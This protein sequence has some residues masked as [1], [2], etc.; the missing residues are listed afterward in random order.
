MSPGPEQS[1]APTG[2]SFPGLL[3]PRASSWA[4]LSPAGIS[5]PPLTAALICF[6]FQEL[7]S[8]VSSFAF[9]MPHSRFRVATAVDGATASCRRRPGHPCGM[10]DLKLVIMLLAL[11]AASILSASARSYVLARLSIPSRSEMY[12]S[13]NFFI[14]AMY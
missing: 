5:D 12:A 13:R 7:S 1:S 2:R 3:T 14:L 8:P 9:T 10:V 4:L 11:V 6:Q